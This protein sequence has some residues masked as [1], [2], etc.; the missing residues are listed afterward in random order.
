MSG[1]V[2]RGKDADGIDV[3]ADDDGD[4][5]ISLNA[6][7]GTMVA[8]APGHP[9]LDVAAGMR[10]EMVRLGCSDVRIFSVSDDG[11]EAPLPTYEEALAALAAARAS[12]LAEA[13][14]WLRDRATATD[15]EVDDDCDGYD[16]DRLCA[17]SDLLRKAADDMEKWSK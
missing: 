16:A 10:A 11:T 4:G 14:T 13:V 9:A 7:E 6:N 1:Y 12:A 3:Y 15:A 2:V 17:E 5:N 8:D